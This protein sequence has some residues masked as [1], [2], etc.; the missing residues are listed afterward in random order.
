MKRL[1]PLV[2][3]LVACLQPAGAALFEDEEAR[4]AILDI[5]QRLDSQRAPTESL[6]REVK[7][8]T[9]D[10][11]QLRRALL[12]LQAQIETLRSEQ[13]QLR[14]DR[15]LAL[16]ELSETQ[17]RIKDLA[18]SFEER[19]RP[20]EPI[21]VTLDG[22]EF[23]AQPAE[24]RDFDAALERFRASEFASAVTAL[25]EF[26]RRYPQSGY[27][28]SALF[29][30]GNAQYATRDYKEAIQNFRTLSTAAPNFVRLPDAWLSLANCQFELKDVKAGRKTLEEL[31]KKYP[32]TEAGDAARERLSRLK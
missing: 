5:R 14:G 16:R 13:S 6:N 4:R 19:L 3:L 24:K 7:T 9:E 26:I 10:N 30:L 22:A 12:D 32:Q 18:Q 20:L 15:D 21:K 23:M 28:P 11:Q 1:L 2:L 31:I 8:L 17:R 25:A 29:W 27:V